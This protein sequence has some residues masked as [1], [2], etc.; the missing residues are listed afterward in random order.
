[1]KKRVLVCGEASFLSTGFSQLQFEFCK[2][3]FE[4]GKYEVAEFANYGKHDDPRRSNIPWGFYSS[5]PTNHEEEV[6]YKSSPFNEFGKY[7][8]DKVVAHFKPDIVFSYLDHWMMTHMF[9]SPARKF[10]KLVIMPTCDAEPQKDEW[11]FSYASA[12]AV[13]TYS[14][15]A[16]NLLRQQSNNKIKLVDWTPPATDYNIFKGC[17][18]KKEFKKQVGFQEDCKIVGTVMRNQARKLYPNLMED[19]SEYLS[20]SGENKTYLYLHTAFPDV[21]WDLFYFIKKFG[22]SSKVMMTYHCK[23]CGNVYPGFIH[24]IQSFCPK[25]NENAGFFPISQNGISREALSGVINLFDVYV[26]YSNAE[27]FGIPVL[28]AAACGVPI[29]FPNYSAMED[30]TDTLGGIPIDIQ[31]KVYEKETNCLRAIPNQQDFIN[32]LDT[33]LSKPQCVLSNIGNKMREKAMANYSWDL[34]ASKLMKIFDELPSANSY[35][36]P[37]SFNS[38]NLNIPQNLSK[39]DFV[40]W[41]II[42]IAHC[43]ELLNSHIHMRILRDLNWGFTLSNPGNDYISEYSVFNERTKF[44][45]F[46]Y[47]SVIGFFLY[48][49]EEKNKFEY[50]RTAK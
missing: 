17:A 15:W 44:T 31:G 34:S 25:C 1:M 18:N 7:K 5:C 10:Y 20:Q 32:K 46:D 50:M 40:K 23:N 14:K 3:F 24:D 48:L 30:F 13:T 22:L 35:D 37:P 43:P 11:I 42:N 45:P 39:E 41:G 9:Y 6:E 26:Q 12:D 19:F 8:F 21:G 47:N 38:P 2:R 49:L 36:L 28:E 4:S 33:L 16:F 27:G 29:L